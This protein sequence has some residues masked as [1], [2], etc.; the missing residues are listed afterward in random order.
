MGA[1]RE[2]TNA[3]GVQW[4]SA[5]VILL[6]VCGGVTSPHRQCVGW[7]TSKVLYAH[8]DHTPDVVFLQ[9]TSPRI[10]KAKIQWTSGPSA[11]TRGKLM[12][13][14]KSRTRRHGDS[15]FGIY[16]LK[17]Q[18]ARESFACTWVNHPSPWIFSPST[19]AVILKST[20]RA[21][22]ASTATTGRV[23]LHSMSNTAPIRNVALCLIF[24]TSSLLGLPD[25]WGF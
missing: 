21:A 22:I 16:S 15:M 20:T 4:C 10:Y 3:T 2:W 17:T 24:V 12:R 11:G 9:L 8:P 18:T 13:S 6:I 1:C 25:K 7:P 19:F 14:G 23:W 5:N